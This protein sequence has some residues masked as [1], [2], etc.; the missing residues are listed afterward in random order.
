MLEQ[1]LVRKSQARGRRTGVD[2]SRSITEDDREVNED[3]TRP[4]S[5]YSW[6]TAADRHKQVAILLDKDVKSCNQQRKTD[7]HA[8]DNHVINDLLFS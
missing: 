3:K 5:R 2:D 7:A 4:A 6:N 8:V 1:L